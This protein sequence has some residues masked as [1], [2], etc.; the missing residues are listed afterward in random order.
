MNTSATPRGIEAIATVP[1]GRGTPSPA[2][3]LAVAEIGANI[4]AREEPSEEAITWWATAVDG[5]V[6]R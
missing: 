6:T 5:Q 3:L 2:A 4:A 1:T